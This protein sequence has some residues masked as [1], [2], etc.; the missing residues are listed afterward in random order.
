[1]YLFMKSYKHDT[2][3]SKKVAKAVANTKKNNGSGQIGTAELMKLL[4]NDT[5][6]PPIHEYVDV[7][8][9]EQAKRV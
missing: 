8:D 6:S 1:M 5:N 3:F 2:F 7:S 4:D 9:E